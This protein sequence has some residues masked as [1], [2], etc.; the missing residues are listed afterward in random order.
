MTI[1]YESWEDLRPKTAVAANVG[2]G[3]DVVLGWLDD[4]FQYPDKLLEVTDIAQ[5]LGDKYGGWFEVPAR[6][7]ARRT[8]PGSACRSAAPAPA[9]S[10]ARRG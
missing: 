7:G 5:Y 8:A 6:Y 3:P 1:D 9:W 4:A 10:T 2:S